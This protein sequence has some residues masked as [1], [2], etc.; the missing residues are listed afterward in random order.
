M[1]WMGLEHGKTDDT[2]DM[3]DNWIFPRPHLF[4]LSLPQSLKHDMTENIS[5]GTSVADKRVSHFLF[6][7]HTPL[8]GYGIGRWSVF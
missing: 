6:F 8:G 7:F 1:I 3:L 5:C 2:M 4:G